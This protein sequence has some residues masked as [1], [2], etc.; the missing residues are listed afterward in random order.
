M[1][2]DSSKLS[3]VNSKYL[4]LYPW[5]PTTH[6]KVCTACKVTVLD[7]KSYSYSP[8]GTSFILPKNANLGALV[9]SL[10]WVPFESIILP[11]TVAPFSKVTVPVV[12]MLPVNVPALIVIVL[13]LIENTELALLSMTMFFCSCYIITISLY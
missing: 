12:V 5:K 9:L 11:D 7:V 13:P 3:S 10:T 4:A 6:F 8:T 2:V 1:T